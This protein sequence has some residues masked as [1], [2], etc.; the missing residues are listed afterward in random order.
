MNNR[1]PNPETFLVAAETIQE[2]IEEGKESCYVCNLLENMRGDNCEEVK[3][4]DDLYFTP[5]TS[6]D[7]PWGYVFNNCCHATF[8]GASEYVYWKAD[9]HRIF[10]LLLAYEIAR[11]SHKYWPEQINDC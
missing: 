1:T 5:F 2:W 9:N 7:V 8:N 6:K 10:A 11:G 4:F 3:F